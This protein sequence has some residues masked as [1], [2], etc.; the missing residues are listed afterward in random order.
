LV[1]AAA[2][3]VVTLMLE[4]LVQEVLQQMVAVDKVALEEMVFL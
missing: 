2:E 3:V 1:L 4:A